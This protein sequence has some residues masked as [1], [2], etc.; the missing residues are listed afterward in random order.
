MPDCRP[1]FFVS[2]RGN[3]LVCSR[4]PHRHSVAALLFVMVA[5]LLTLTGA[6]KSSVEECITG[7]CLNGGT[8]KENGTCVCPEK[9]KGACCESVKISSV[10]LTPLT[11]RSAA[12]APIC[13]ECFNGGTRYYSHVHAGYKCLCPPYHDGTCCEVQEGSY[14]SNAQMYLWMSVATSGIVLLLVCLCV[15]CGCKRLD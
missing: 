5:S 6:F 11:R 8:L 12:T 14:N 13:E 2:S 15:L 10:P 9:F 3:C 7:V 1:Q 4:R